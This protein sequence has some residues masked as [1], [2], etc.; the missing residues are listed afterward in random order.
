M[1]ATARSD[2]LA[3]QAKPALAGNPVPARLRALEVFTEIF[4]HTHCARRL[5]V[6]SKMKS[7]ARFSEF[8]VAP[9]VS[10]R[11]ESLVMDMR[12][13]LCNVTQLSLD[14]KMFK[15][16]GVHRFVCFN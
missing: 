11:S 15:L 7:D 3:Q 13:S 6:L 1:F 10:T 8:F 14:I 4:V 16:Y 2:F 9:E 5:R 12:N